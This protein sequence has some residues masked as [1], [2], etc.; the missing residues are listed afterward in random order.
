[1]NSGGSD[2]LS[3]GGAYTMI[4]VQTL[5]VAVGGVLFA[6]RAGQATQSEGDGCLLAIA[7]LIFAVVGAGIGFFLAPYPYFVA[8]SLLGSAALC[9]AAN[10]WLAARMRRR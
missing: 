4:L 9:L 8:T 2:W 1:M 3:S 6:L 5:A 10:T 7:N